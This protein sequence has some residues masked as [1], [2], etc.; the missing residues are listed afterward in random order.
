[1]KT[2]FLLLLSIILLTTA[3]VHS[4]NDSVEKVDGG[5]GIHI[6]NSLFEELKTDILAKGFEILMDLD[7]PDQSITQDLAGLITVDGTL[8]NIT[9]TSVG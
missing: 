4:S 5:I 2:A 3:S 6:A 9:I 8:S 7:I 1:M